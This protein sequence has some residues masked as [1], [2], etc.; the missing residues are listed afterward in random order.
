[1]AVRQETMWLSLLPTF[2]CH[3]P[4]V[5]PFL[6]VP[7]SMVVILRALADLPLASRRLVAA[8]WP[9][10]H[11]R[12]LR[13]V[14]FSFCLL[15]SLRILRHVHFEEGYCLHLQTQYHSSAWQGLRVLSWLA[16]HGVVVLLARLRQVPFRRQ[17][18][19]RIYLS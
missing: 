2:S 5:L 19:T 7:G 15:A 11:R 17:W 9:C 12:R 16:S 4:S 6:P 8:C 18:E 13:R 3:P 14:H 10:P 1:M